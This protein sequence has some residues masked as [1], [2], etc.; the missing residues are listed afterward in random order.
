MVR[1]FVAGL[2]KLVF[3]DCS[4]R[5]FL[6]S[7]RAGFLQTA[8]QTVKQVLRLNDLETK[9]FKF[10][11]FLEVDGTQLLTCAFQLLTRAFECHLDLISVSRSC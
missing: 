10:T 9:L 8:L 6:K 1:Q 2:R 5:L 3:K 7:L 4:V 11:R